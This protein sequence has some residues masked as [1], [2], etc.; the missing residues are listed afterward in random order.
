MQTECESYVMVREL[1][2]LNEEYQLAPTQLKSIILTDIRLIEDALD[3]L[4]VNTSPP[5]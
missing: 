3:L 4:K 5:M 1:H 2:H